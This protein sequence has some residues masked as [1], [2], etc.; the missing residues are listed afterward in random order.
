MFTCDSRSEML[1]SVEI[2]I[3]WITLAQYRVQYLDV[4]IWY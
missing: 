2:T 3:S 4:Q 1:Q